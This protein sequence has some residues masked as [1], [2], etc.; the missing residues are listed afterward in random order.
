MLKKQQQKVFTKM[1]QRMS[2]P[3]E[4]SKTDHT[5]AQLTS[6]TVLCNNSNLQEK[7]YYSVQQTSNEKKLPP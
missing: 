2:A 1:H 3:N 6:R 7:R 5:N 4:R